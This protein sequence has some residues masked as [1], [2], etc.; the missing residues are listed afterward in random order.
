MMHIA[1]HVA[2]ASHTQAIEQN[3]K[4]NNPT[5]VLQVLIK[6]A[7]VQA[8]HYPQ[9]TCHKEQQEAISRRRNRWRSAGGGIAGKPS[10]VLV[11]LS[12]TIHADVADM[13]GPVC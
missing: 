11:P 5:A 1:A 8:H 2:P 6:Q 9:L 3:S 7:N 4:N 12:A 13:L 10:S